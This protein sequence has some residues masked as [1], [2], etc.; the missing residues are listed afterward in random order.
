MKRSIFVTMPAMLALI[1]AVALSGCT[2]SGSDE[3]PSPTI[4]PTA[5]ATPVVTLTPEQKSAQTILV[6]GNLQEPMNLTVADLQKY[7]QISI[8]INYSS[9]HVE[10]HMDA[11]GAS[12]NAVLDSFKV[13]DNATTLELTGADGYSATVWISE[14]RGDN[15]SILAIDSEPNGSLRVIIPSQ[16][17]G[18]CWV[19]DLV[20]IR[21]K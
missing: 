5:T 20:S 11:S 16:Y 7:P 21:V 2:S 14:I 8:S 13:Y 1:I 18:T 15:Q 19:Y 12:L 10:R 9:Q 3:S 4:S 6:T 17:Y